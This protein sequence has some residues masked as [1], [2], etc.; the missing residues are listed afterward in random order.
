MRFAARCAQYL[1]LLLPIYSINVCSKEALG[2]ETL[3]LPEID[4]NSGYLVIAL[5]L[6]VDTAKIQITGPH[7]EKKYVLNQKRGPFFSLPLRRGKYKITELH[8]PYFDFPYVVD[9]TSDPR[10]HFK[11][12]KKKINYLGEIHIQKLRTKKTVAFEIYNNTEKN[13]KIICAYDSDPCAHF[14]FRFS[15]LYRDDYLKELEMPHEK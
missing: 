9:L 6:E 11:I 5:D 7:G 12:D 3:K 15:A 13:R 10:W 2:S 4:G 8:V 14:P 1:L